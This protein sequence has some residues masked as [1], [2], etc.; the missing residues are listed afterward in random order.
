MI[1]VGIDVSRVREGMTGAGRYPAGI[2]SALDSAMPDA[3]FVLYAYR[4][5]SFAPSSSR[6]HIVQDRHPFWSR[7]PVTMWMHSRIG[8][9]IKKT[10]VDVFWSPNT[11]V[12]RGVS[13]P[14]VLTVLDFNHVI[15]PETLPP[16]TRYSH[17]KWMNA[18][19]LAA[20]ANVSISLGTAQRMLE[21]LGRKT[22]AIAYPAVSGRS[23]ILDESKTAQ[24]LH[25]AGVN[26]P[27]FLTVGTRAPRKN[28]AAA[29]AA[30]EQLRDAGLCLNH[31][32]VMAGPEA[33]DKQGRHIERGHDWIRPLGFVEDDLLSALY[34]NAEALVFPS[35]YEGFGM[36]VIEA[37]A[38]GCRVVTTDSPEL[39]E[40]GG[41]DA[42]YTDTSPD[43]IAAGIRAA[44]ARPR[45]LPRQIEH[46]WEDAA[47]Q[48]ASVFRKLAA[49]GSTG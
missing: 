21:L 36:P 1:R 44:L 19:I 40:A 7:I 3:T 38:H 13:V 12:P 37:R 24:L 10:P 14:C 27:Y 5:T 8:A 46:S 2:L 22:D 41:D 33:W 17:R 31:Q 42:V 29:V 48:M 32:L 26:K 34:A 23:P 25:R 30:I 28:L 18:D 49:R 16:L 11:F 4:E 6:W 39:H 9:L 35:L 47:E 15:V 20:D 43:G 45:P